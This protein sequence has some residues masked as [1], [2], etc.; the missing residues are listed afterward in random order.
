MTVY[1][2]RGIKMRNDHI[3]DYHLKQYSEPYRSTVIF[4]DWLEQRVALN[5]QRILDMACGAGANLHYFGCLHRDSQFIGIDYDL[6]TLTSAPPSED[7]VRLEQGDW[8]H[9]NPKYVNAFNGIIS[10]QTLSWLS[11]YKVPIEKLCE[12]NPD[13]ISLTSLFYE[14]RITY[15]I[16]LE[17]EEEKRT[18]YYNIYSLPKVKELFAQ[19]GYTRFEYKKFEIDI[20]LPKLDTYCMK[21]YTEQ[22]SDGRRLQFSGALLMPWYFILAQK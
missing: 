1:F 2:D 9:I 10:L 13:W 4:H 20:D 19:L 6:Q 11:D 14:G 7:N 8:F 3:K 12:L 15:Y 16:R 17:D 5:G 18:C 22:I 21:T